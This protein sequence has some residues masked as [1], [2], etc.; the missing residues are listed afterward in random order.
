MDALMRHILFIDD[1]EALVFL[2]RRLLQNAG[3]AVTAC[4]SASA[5]LQLLQVQSHGFD[6]VVS[7]LNMPGM[8]GLE[9]ARQVLAQ[10]PQLP[11]V[12]VSGYVYPDQL[13][14][15][16]ALG[17]RKLIHKPNSINELV[18]ELAALL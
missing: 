13:Q 5:A 10:H 8:S 2:M 9:F 17:V 3:Y 11:L 12:I 4:V 7:D 16:A 18:R 14:Q 15:A 1:D 6:L